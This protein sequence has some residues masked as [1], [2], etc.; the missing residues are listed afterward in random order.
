M[1]K[2]VRYNQ[3]LI[4]SITVLAAFMVSSCSLDPWVGGKEYPNIVTITKISSY[5]KSAD[6]VSPMKSAVGAVKFSH[7]THEDA[8]VKCINCHHK[9][10]N[11][12]RI[13][14]CASCH[15]GDNGYETMHGLCVDCHIEKKEGPQHC[16]EC[17]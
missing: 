12:D 14:Q 11:P 1:E 7:K 9:K 15:R 13:K 3:V 17:H 6:G 5:G 4:A 2:A 16:K 10:D 8:G